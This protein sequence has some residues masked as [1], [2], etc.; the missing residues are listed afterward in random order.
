MII[1]T[2]EF[3]CAYCERKEA[4]TNITDSKLQAILTWHKQ[5]LCK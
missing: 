4:H 5:G 1:E 2:F 3:I